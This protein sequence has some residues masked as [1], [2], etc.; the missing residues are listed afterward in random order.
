MTPFYPE[1]FNEALPGRVTDTRGNDIDMNEI[2]W[3]RI[4]EHYILGC[5]HG[6][7]NDK[8]LVGGITPYDSS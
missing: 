6:G 1:K 8:C 4:E 2:S 3:C 7:N 5:F